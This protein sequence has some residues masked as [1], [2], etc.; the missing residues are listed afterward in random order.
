MRR[1]ILIM[2][3]LI[4]MILPATDAGLSARGGSGNKLPSFLVFATDP[5]FTLNTTV[6]APGPARVKK[7]ESLKKSIMAIKDP[8]VP[9]PPQKVQKIAEA[10][11]H[12]QEKTGVNATFM[13]ALARME[14]D[15]RS[16]IL[17]NAP[18]KLN[19]RTTGC[20]ADCGM[21]Q[22]HVRGSRAYVKT[23]CYKLRRNLKYSFYK[24]AEEI[25]H[26][27]KWCQK[28][29]SF[30]KPLRR[31]VLNRYNQGPY[32]KT[33]YK[34]KKRYKCH[35]M[36]RDLARETKDEYHRRYMSCRRSLYKCYGHAAYWKILSCFEYGARNQIKSKRR[37]RQCRYLTQIKTRF[38]PPLPTTPPPRRAVVAVK[39][40]PRLKP[41]RP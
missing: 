20:F 13:I 27:V 9:M 8:G 12:A 26:H 1:I 5:L 32:Y 17:I 23:Q 18:C 11:L 28:Y 10:A 39:P 29:K 6:P 41:T 3:G 37:C 15:F 14:S 34:C 19:L 40:T 38:Y 21:T 24:S 4:V 33:A 2:V 31:C 22:H 7:L 25:A 30:S 16:L 36:R 35:L